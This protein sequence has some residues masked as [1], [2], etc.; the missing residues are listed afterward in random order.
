MTRE[1]LIKR[2]EFAIYKEF[3]LMRNELPYKTG[4]LAYR[5]FNLRKT[6]YGWD[7]FVDLTI[8]PYAIYLDSKPKTQG[9]WRDA[10]KRF[11]QRLM[12]DLQGIV[13]NVA[14]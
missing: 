8:S 7:L 10:C 3:T 14:V 13:G 4:R 2:I 11:M 1:Y 12:I 9:W 6:E 5:A